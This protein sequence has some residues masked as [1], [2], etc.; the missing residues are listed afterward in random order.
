MRLT[1]PRIVIAGLAGDSGKTLVALGLARALAARGLAVAPLEKGPDYID[2]G[3]LGAA[4]GRTARNL[5]TFMD[6]TAGVGEVVARSFPADLL[7][8]EGNRGLFDG[9]DVAGT[10]STAALAKLLG[11][12]VILVVDVTK[13]TRT[14]AALVRG[15]QLFDPELE[16]GV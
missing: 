5:D 1:V 12:T 16:V 9:M 7:L 4:A 13:M 14:A 6:G 10:H 8:V 11:A 3:W 15:C 2:A